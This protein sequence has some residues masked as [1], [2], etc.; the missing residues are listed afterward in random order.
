MKFDDRAKLTKNEL[1]RKL[2]EIIESKK[3]LLCLAADVTSTSQLLELASKVGPHIC[4]LK[5]HFD[6][7]EDFSKNTYI[8][9]MKLA[10]NLNF[11]IMEDRQVFKIKFKTEISTLW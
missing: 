3:S 2:F 11:L 4:I 7:L 6:L 9:L 5:T 1:G 8:E 10:K